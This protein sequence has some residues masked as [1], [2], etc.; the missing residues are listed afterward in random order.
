MRHLKLLS[1]LILFSFL[2]TAGFLHAAKPCIHML[3]DKVD[4]NILHWVFL[5]ERLPS[6]N[7]EWA[8]ASGVNHGKI[9]GTGSYRNQKNSAKARLHENP[10]QA[11]EALLEKVQVSSIFQDKAE[12]KEKLI[13]ELEEKV[14]TSRNRKAKIKSSTTPHE[15]LDQADERVLEWILK[16][17]RSPVGN[18]EWNQAIG[19]NHSKYLGT[20]S[21]GVGGPAR[22]A[23]IH[24]S[25]ADA[26][27]ALIEKVKV[28]PSLELKSEL[29]E[30]II[31][32][33]NDK[34]LKS[35][36]EFVLPSK[37][38]RAQ[39]AEDSFIKWVLINQKF[40]IGGAPWKQALGI[41]AEKYFGTGNFKVGK[42]QQH[43]QIYASPRE[44][45]ESLL[46]KV[47]SSPELS[48]QKEL[49]LKIIDSLKARLAQ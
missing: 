32:D 40:P 31:S 17:E 36:G 29:K 49:Q 7:L 26:Y 25:P 48:S 28:A 44:G 41:D 35:L 14:E 9:F 6:G 19:F 5:N 42:K 47:E 18:L 1:F 33:L 21:Y 22:E 2:L 43:L 24:D 45:L 46:K 30:K 8:Q 13:R 11:Y 16:N 39:S 3:R 23:R 12:L 20:G 15:L 34:K 27:S 10:H 38:E 4:Q 37:E